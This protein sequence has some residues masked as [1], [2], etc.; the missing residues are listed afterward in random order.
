MAPRKDDERSLV[1]AAQ[2]DPARL[3][4]LYDLHFHRVWAFVIRRASNRTEAEDIT[5]EVFR[6]AFEHLPRYQWRG[7]PFVA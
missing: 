5:S 7:T 6:R 2:A 4:K 3:L 1:E